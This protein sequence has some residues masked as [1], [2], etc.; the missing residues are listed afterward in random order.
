[1]PTPR[2]GGTGGGHARRRL[3]LLVP[4]AAVLIGGGCTGD[5]G[6]DGE[7][8]ARVTAGEMVEVAVGG[9]WVAVDVDD[10]IPA[11]ARL[12]TGEAET[13][14]AFRSGEV[15]LA[16]Q[17][18]ALITD[19]HVELLR[20]EALVASS[21]D[22]QA[23]WRDVAVAGA[24]VYRLTPGISPRLGVYSGQ[25]EVHR[26]PEVRAVSALREASLSSRRLPAVGRPL[27][28]RPDDPWD[29]VLLGDALAFDDEAERLGLGLER[30]YGIAPKPPE[31]YAGFTRT[32]E[33]T[34]PVL[35]TSTDGDGRLGPPGETLLQL[36]VAQSA[37]DQ[38]G[39]VV[40]EDLL[41]QVVEL[42]SNGARWGLVAAEL[43]VTA[44]GL[45][46][47]VDVGQARR[48]AV[49]ERLTLADPPAA[50]EDGAP[51]RDDASPPPPAHPA[52]PA[53]PPPPS[54]PPP[55]APGPSGDANAGSNDNA[56]PPPPPPPP[57][58]QQEQEPPPQP[59]PT[60]LLGQQPDKDLVE[61]VV[62]LLLE[63]D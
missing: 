55:S 31:F 25:V 62:D 48:A 45:A 59:N 49:V 51:T 23:R 44:Q 27:A 38:D 32:P 34:V 42:R 1:M 14:M 43:D 2:R 15:W 4:L 9:N 54:A 60:N 12:R 58:Q 47:T 35:A 39:D 10:E 13:H 19:D 26:G 11:G 20:G 28:Y 56:P 40:L 18:A 21:G 7:A 24:G 61:V 46:K 63:R 17:A 41:R 33:R 16:P 52:S 3:A 22:L 29:R 6:L 37:A 5:D 8:V 50:D 36:F 30:L 53:P 57:P